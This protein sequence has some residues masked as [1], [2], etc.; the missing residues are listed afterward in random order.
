M[1]CFFKCPDN[2][3]SAYLAHTFLQR[4]TKGREYTRT[5]IFCNQECLAKFRELYTTEDE[6][7]INYVNEVMDDTQDRDPL[8]MHSHVR[9]YK[10]L[11]LLLKKEAVQSST[12]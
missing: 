8:L 4:D 2:R 3:Q 9:E 5:C 1:A 6:N 10:Q 11:L 12:H 7:G